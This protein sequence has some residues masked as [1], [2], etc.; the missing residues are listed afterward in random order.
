MGIKG[1]G[2]SKKSPILIIKSRF[3]YAHYLWA[4]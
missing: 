1:S 3:G 4:L 2:V